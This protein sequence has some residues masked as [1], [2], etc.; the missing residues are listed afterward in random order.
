MAGLTKVNNP[1]ECVLTR[2][3]HE[4]VI[5]AA[6]TAAAIIWRAPFACQ[7]VG[8]YERHSVVGSTNAAA[9]YKKVPAGVTAP[10]AGTNLQSAA[11]DLTAAINTE[12]AATLAADSVCQ[13]AEGDCISRNLS[14]TLT[15]LVGFVSIVFKR[16]D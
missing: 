15:N 5:L 11:F 1:A 9:V 10:G 8:I 4:D 3:T 14:G 6:S 12:V 7:V 16:I 2:F 13:L